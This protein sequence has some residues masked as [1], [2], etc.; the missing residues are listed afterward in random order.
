MLALFLVAVVARLLVAASAHQPGA[1]MSR[2]RIAIFVVIALA[3]VAAAV[4]WASSRRPQSDGSDIVIG[5]MGPLTGDAAAYGRA[6]QNGTTLALEEAENRLP[7][8]RRSI[9]IIFEDDRAEAALGRTVF[10][11]LAD[12]INTPLIVQAAG[13]SVMLSNIPDAQSRGIVYISPSCSNDEIRNGGDFIFRTWPS[14]LYQA[15]YLSEAVSTRF[16]ARRVAILYID[17]AYGSG[18][19]QAFRSSFEAG[20]GTVVLYEPVQVGGTDFRAQLLRVRTAAPDVIFTPVQALEAS[21]LIR[22]A[23]ELRVGGRFVADAVLYSQDFLEAA[24]D[25]ANGVV[26]SNLAWNPQ[27]SPAAAEF[28]ARYQARFGEAPDIYAAAGYDNARIILQALAATDDTSSGASIRDALL[29]LPR[30]QGVTGELQFD[31][32]GEVRVP[33]ELNEIQNGAFVVLN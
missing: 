11:F 29:Q 7:N 17:N 26:V 10:S 22:Q 15:E 18:L 31:E 23:R 13:S 21:R 1:D 2:Q 4:W 28:A 32:N 27:R 3:A 5:W 24:G 33:Y 12:R 19:A 14:D 8:S 25:A 30:F 20:G 16:S 9:R 6:I